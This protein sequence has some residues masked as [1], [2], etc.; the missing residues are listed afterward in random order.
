MT[1]T[2]VGYLWR[3]L[4]AGLKL[5]HQKYPANLIIFLDIT[6]QYIEMQTF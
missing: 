3:Q 2:I 1:E 5:C 6:Y 4:E